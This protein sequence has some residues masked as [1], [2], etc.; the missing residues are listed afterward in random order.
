MLMRG[1]GLIYALSYR[2]CEVPVSKLQAST[3]DCH[4]LAQNE[5]EEILAL[6][7][8]TPRNPRSGYVR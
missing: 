5:H 7:G 8:E 6:L 4:K 1:S 3:E 2:Q